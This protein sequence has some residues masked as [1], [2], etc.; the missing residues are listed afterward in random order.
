M[1]VIADIDPPEHY[2]PVKCV[3][4]INVSTDKAWYSSMAG[5]WIEYAGCFIVWQTTEEDR[6]EITKSVMGYV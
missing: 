5:D 3:W 1:K 6:L 2:K 4:W